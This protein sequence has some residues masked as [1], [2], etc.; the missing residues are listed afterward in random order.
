MTKNVVTIDKDTS[1][2]D[3]TLKLRKS[4]ISG[5]PVL[6]EEKV[7]GVFSEADLLNQLPD[8]LE[9]ADLIPMVDV[10]ELTGAPVKDVMGT[11]V[12]TCKPND[13][14]KDV[15]KIFLE[16]FIHRLPVIDENDKLVGVI[17]LGDVLTAF[18]EVEK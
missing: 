10:Q 16:K 4:K 14:L 2:R 12:I 11:P 8:I 6:D 3:A 15:A 5:M 17:S 7:V 13:D 18:I 1:I 9:E